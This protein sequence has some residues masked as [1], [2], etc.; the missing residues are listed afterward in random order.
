MKVKHC[1]KNV[2]DPAKILPMVKKCIYRAY[3]VVMTNCI[4]VSIVEKLLFFPNNNRIL[5]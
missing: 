3:F 2:L 1:F 5:Q 4:Y